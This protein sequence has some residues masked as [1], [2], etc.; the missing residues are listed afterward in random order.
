M[1]GMS[2]MFYQVMLR[3][4]NRDSVNIDCFG[5][6]NARCSTSGDQVQILKWSQVGKIKD[7]AKIDIES[8]KP[9]SG[10]DAHSIMKSMR[11]I[12]SKFI[13]VRCGAW[14]NVTGRTGQI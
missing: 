11:G 12:L 7:R 14:A 13:I 8:F 6:V 9:L 5:R 4:L 2:A 3:N 10:E 1:C